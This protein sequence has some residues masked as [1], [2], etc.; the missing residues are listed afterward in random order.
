MC[1][2]SDHIFRRKKRPQLRTERYNY[3]LFFGN[4]TLNMRLTR[5]AVNSGTYT[6]AIGTCAYNLRLS[7][8]VV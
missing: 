4:A 5:R 8:Q 3:E 7:Y 2:K 6:N 1:S